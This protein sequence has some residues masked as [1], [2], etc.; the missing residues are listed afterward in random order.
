MQ[1]EAPFPAF[2]EFHLAV[3]ALLRELSK[4]GEFTGLKWISD[5]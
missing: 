3:P 1:G 2:A 4:P 5:G